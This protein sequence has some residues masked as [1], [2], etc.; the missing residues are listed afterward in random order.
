MKKRSRAAI[1]LALSLAASLS[2]RQRATQSASQ[3]QSPS[4]RQPPQSQPAP[5][6]SPSSTPAE[7]GEDEVVR[8]TTNLVQLDVVVTDKRGNQV[9]DL[10]V[11]DFEVLQDGRPQQITN[12]SYVAART[13]APAGDG[14]KLD[15]TTTPARAAERGQVRRTIA[16]VVDDLGLSFPSTER[17]RQALREFVEKQIGPGDLVAILR[18]G[19]GG[20][21]L[22]QFTSDKRL[23]LSAVERIR[24]VPLG[25]GELTEFRA[26]DSGPVGGGGSVSDRLDAIDKLRKSQRDA[27]LLI[28][29]FNSLGSV[30]EGMHTLPGR[31][32]VIFYSDG[33]DI[34]PDPDDPANQRKRDALR[35]LVDRASRS[36]VAFYTVDARGLAYTGLT[37]SDSTGGTTFGGG[38][39]TASDI[40]A[41]AS[42][43]RLTLEATQFG[44]QYLAR[45]LG[46]F[47]VQNTNALNMGRVLEDLSGYYLVGYRPEGATF[48]KQFHKIAARVKGRPDL[49]VRTR[50]GFYG[51][52][53]E[54]SRPAELPADRLARALVSPF[55]SGEIGLQLTPLFAYSAATGETLRT[56][57][58]IE[59]R[60]LAFKDQPDGWHAADIV[61]RGVLFGDDGKVAE[62]HDGSYTVRLRGK[63]YERA[64]AHGF[65]YSFN[66]P[67][68]KV[69]FY[70]YRVALLDPASSRVGSAGQ[71]VEI[72]DLRRGTLAL[73]GVLMKGVA[74]PSLPKSAA[75]DIAQAKEGVDE[76][77]GAGEKETAQEKETAAVSSNAA[78][79]ARVADPS[80]F[81]RRFRASGAVDYSYVIYNARPDRKIGMTRVTAVARLFRE[82]QLV[83]SEESRIEVPQLFGA[84]RLLNGGRLELAGKYPPGDYALQIVVTDPLADPKH[85]TATQWIDFEIVK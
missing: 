64:L 75:T 53:E 20:G 62:E 80:P 3:P 43:R 52:T 30:A 70:Q 58:H 17:V 27:D 12:F 73:S 33:F 42:E 35:R 49:T 81:V 41:K 37:A 19:A 56:L 76:K 34:D 65:N 5:R 23:L 11:E 14:S 38:T 46:G 29:T 51:L 50:S 22:Q 61:V 57:L 60:D 66:M 36:A 48:N 79:D 8:I 4:A 47:G 10:K 1:L 24:W 7:V 15:E 77:E 69:G 67:V 72:P 28:D 63:T 18:T 31:K 40:D 6:P 16:L 55:S 68:N 74:D 2:A 32:A 9:T 59:A 26:I 78:G 54:E 71:P 13:A 45:E 21:A 82:G 25:R 83:S 84:T 39:M 85:R 44:L